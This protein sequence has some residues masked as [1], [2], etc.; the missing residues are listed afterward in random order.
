[1]KWLYMAKG[2]NLFIEVYIHLFNSRV[3]QLLVYNDCEINW[4][5]KAHNIEILNVSN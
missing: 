4:P 5:G 3:W 1:M 2:L